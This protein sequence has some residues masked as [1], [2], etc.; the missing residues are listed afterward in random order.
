MNP[1]RVK[2]RIQSWDAEAGHGTVVDEQGFSYPLE[3]RQL[4]PEF[5]KIPP[6][7]L[8]VLE[9][10]ILGP[11]QIKDVIDPHNRGRQ[12]VASYLEKLAGTRIGGFVLT[13]QPAPGRWGA[14]TYA[15]EATAVEN[16]WGS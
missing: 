7:H 6:R 2:L 9:G 3:L 13:R 16:T 1:I 4:P 11:G 8:E 12:Y 10:L 5:T 15:L 14:A